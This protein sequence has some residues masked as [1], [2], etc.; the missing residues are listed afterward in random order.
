MS[1]R[2]DDEREGHAPGS[3]LIIR[4]A[5][6][7]VQRVERATDGWFYSVVGLSELVRGQEAV[8]SSAIDAPEALDPRQAR[9]TLDDS[10]RHRDARLWLEAT[11]RK[12]AV[13]L[14]DPALSVATEG[15]V[16]ALPY[17][18]DACRQALDPANL[19]PRILLADAVGLGKTIEIGMILAE[20]VRRG[21]GERILVVTPK[22]VL[23]QT[24]FELWT[25]FA[26]PFV[27]LDSLGIQ[28]IRRELPATRNPFAHFKRVIISIDTL[29]S[30]RYHAHLGKQKWDAVV[31]D[32]SHN[33]TNAN[34]Q[35]NRLARLLSEQTDALILASATPHNGKADSFAELVR[36]LEPTAV[37]P[38]GE[39][40]EPEVQRLIVR[41]HRHSPEVRSVVGQ[42]W[43]ERKEPNNV[44]VVANEAENAVAAE[45]DATW[46][47]PPD[48]QQVT[49]SGSQLVPWTLAK[50]FLSSPAALVASVSERLGRTEHD[51]ERRALVRLKELAERNLA[52][53]S[54]K[55]DAL[56]TELKRIGI[57]R[58]SDERVVIFAERVQ[59]LSWL[60]E[61]LRA[62]LKLSDEQVVVLHGGLSDVEQQDVVESFKQASSPIRVLVT[63]DVASEGVNL[64]LQ[65]HELIHYDIPWSLIR[66]EQRNG[67]IDRYGQRHSPQI[68]A[69]LLDPDTQAFGGDL[70][71]LERLMQKEHEAH[72]A[73]GD[74]ASLMGKYD[75]EAEERAIREVLAGRADLDDVVKTPDEV[76]SGGGIA[77]L[78][79]AVAP[80][81]ASGNTA[82]ASAPPADRPASAPEPAL[83][84]ATALFPNPS[85][86]LHDALEAAFITPR[87]LPAAGGVSW[88]ERSDLGLVSFAPPADLR[89]R[90][91]V[92]PQSYLKERRVTEH[93]QL[94]V[95]ADRGDRAL[96][97]AKQ[98]ESDSLWPASHYL[99]PLHPALEWAADRALVA[100]GRNEVFAIAAPE[101]VDG[102]AVLLQASLANRRGQVVA[103]STILVRF[104]DPADP[105]IS[106]AQP[107]GG[108]GEAIAAL[109]L[110]RDWINTQAIRSHD[111][112]RLQPLI[113]AA[114]DAA[115]IEVLDQLFAAATNDVRERV[116]Q[117][118][119]RVQGWERD[120]EDLFGS[121]Q[122]RERRRVVERERDLAATMVPEQR[123]VRPL[124]VVAR[125]GDDA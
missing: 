16:D 29:K 26:L 98:R 39:L 54:A 51:P 110:D 44:R 21:R 23:E 2:G 92:L 50:A 34:T 19:R 96:A 91:Q 93:L 1:R 90:L 103:A 42:M 109:G 28:R 100:L 75:V 122:L 88:E 64:H 115:R 48:G 112:P 119:G 43:A 108:I 114:V 9:V 118:T 81:S 76:V 55:F 33:V 27:R 30:D 7:M 20:L 86:F 97:D 18:L 73:L 74:S 59:T 52:E 6:W 63:G 116:A 101:G 22:H 11:A 61:Q 37:T 70:R 10:P 3:V 77:A 17:Q 72:R 79:A 95:T 47:H 46:L 24:Q 49:A 25:R 12:S 58:N 62:T 13:P 15:L 57:A 31:I 80:P 120:A 4:D 106:F 113:P 67:R 41:R 14:T 102:A 45:L 60:R 8:F 125:P 104:P 68:T 35:N 85:V 89:Q 82:G 124:L 65:C 117:W 99:A 94:A 53:G 66:I 123:N 69:L 78:L 107:T 40:I 71:V 38:S 32:E 83:A 84:Q 56:L 36:M 5:T 87:A 105:T 121:S 111:L